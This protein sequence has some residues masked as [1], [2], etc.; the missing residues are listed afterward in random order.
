MTVELT[1]NSLT[2]EQVEDVVFGQAQPRLSDQGRAKMID[3]RKVI[4]HV[5]A[6]GSRVYG[7][8]TGF[9]KMASVEISADQIRQLQVNLV[10][11]HACGVGALLSEHEVRAL[12]LLRANALAKGYSGIRPL[13]VDTLCA[14]LDRGVHP[15]IPVKDQ[16]EHRETWPP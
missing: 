9:G 7:V 10:R 15:V 16:W 2:R 13:A 1:G 6:N 8:N 5:I 4:E 11:S 3:S 14:M 12:M